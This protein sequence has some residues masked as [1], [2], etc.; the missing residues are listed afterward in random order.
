METKVLTRSELVKILGV[1]PSALKTIENEA[2]LDE[3]GRKRWY[4]SA[5]L[6]RLVRFQKQKGGAVPQPLET[7]IRS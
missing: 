5:D 2:G 7:F 1:Q 6:G 4:S 3:A